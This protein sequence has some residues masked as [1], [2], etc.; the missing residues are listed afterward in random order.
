MKIAI[1]LVQGQLSQHFGHCEE[2]ALLEIASDS[3]NIIAKTMHQPPPHEP[4]VLPRWLSELGANIIIA[5]GMG[6]RAQELFT[7]NGIKVVVGAV[8]ETPDK[9]A[10]DY[11]QNALV[12][13]ENCCDH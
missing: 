6:R 7:E 2:F 12:V 1:P 3:K 4:G 11:L 10:S 5:G 9:L 13:G 8:S